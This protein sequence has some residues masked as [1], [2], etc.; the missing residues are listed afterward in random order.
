[1]LTCLLRDHDP[2][3]KIRFALKLTLLGQQQYIC[4]IHVNA[5]FHVMSEYPHLFR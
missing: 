1:M 4:L 5:S 2:V 3:G